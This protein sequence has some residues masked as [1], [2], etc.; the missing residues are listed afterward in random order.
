MLVP[1]LIILIS[2]EFDNDDD[3]FLTTLH[4]RRVR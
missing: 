1:I 2:Y 4:G 3:L